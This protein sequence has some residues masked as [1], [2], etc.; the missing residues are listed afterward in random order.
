MTSGPLPSGTFG[1][2]Q[3]DIRNR[4]KSAGGVTYGYDPEGNRIS[5]TDV[6][7][8]TT[9]YLV[10]NSLGLSKVFARTK[11]GQTTRYVWGAG[12]LYEVDASGNAIYY[13]YDQVGSTT[14]L[15]NDAAVVVERI[16]YAP[17]G[18]ITHRKNTSGTAH[19]TP[20]L[21]TGFFGNQTD[22]N[23]LIHMRERYYNPLTRRFL[24]SDPA[25]E[26]GNWFAYAAGNPLAFVDPTGLGITSAINSVQTALSYLGMI[27]VF[28]EV[29][30][31]VNA[32]I[33]LARGNYGEAAINLASALP[34]LGNA[35]G[36]AKIA[37]AHVRTL[38]N[39]TK[40]TNKAATGLARSGEDLFV[41]T[42]NQVRAGNLK[43]G[44]NATHTPHH[45]VQAAVSNASSRGA[46]VSIN[47]RKDLH[48]MTR[49]YRQAV[50]AAP[51]ARTHLARDIRDLRKILSR[52]GYSQTTINAQLKE[53]IRQN[54]ALGGFAK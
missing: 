23:G 48:E 12:L 38:F 26:G 42:Y 47:L 1:I 54:K 24:N 3:Y 51:N 27:P 29:F 40:S 31:V 16:E 46:G 20:F 44:L 41:G 6:A 22:A 34:G 5:A 8:G 2:Y 50:E 36:G 19:D 30:D 49:T 11:G 33:S 45:S 43:S 13:H 17:F 7:T 32:G 10:E 4:L 37:T 14:A 53:L 35:I 52:A 18:W 15:T 25:R 9:T 28:G 21:Y 39:V